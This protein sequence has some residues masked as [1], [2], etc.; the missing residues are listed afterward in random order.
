MIGRIGATAP[1]SRFGA[2]AILLSLLLGGALVLPG[3][4]LWPAGRPA[5]L[6]DSAMPGDGSERP[7]PQAQNGN[8]LAPAIPS[9]PAGKPAPSPEPDTP[10]I[11]LPADWGTWTAPRNG[12]AVRPAP[13]AAVTAPARRPAYH[14]HA[15]PLSAC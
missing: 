12:P 14:A 1:K 7:D 3:P 10:A 4:T 9:T 8:A 5:V 2:W 13:A 11:G 6:A 15:P